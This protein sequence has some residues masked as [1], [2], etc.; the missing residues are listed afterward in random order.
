MGGCISVGTPRDPSLGDPCTLR[1]SET[2]HE[3]PKPDWAPTHPEGSDSGGEVCLPGFRGSARS[4]RRTSCIRAGEPD[5]AV[6]VTR[7]ASS[8]DLS[9]IRSRRNRTHKPL[10]EY[11]SETLFW[12]PARLHAHL[13]EQPLGENHTSDR[14]TTPEPPAPQWKR[15]DHGLPKWKAGWFFLLRR[16]Q[17]EADYR[18]ACKVLRLRF[19]VSAG[20]CMKTPSSLPAACGD[21]RWLPVFERDQEGG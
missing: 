11:S 4:S 18:P 7:A 1:F 10:M 13:C 16:T 19:P 17:G 15:G 5:S 9:K 3:I 21:K 12:A 2:R 8:M 6:F 14:E 20:G